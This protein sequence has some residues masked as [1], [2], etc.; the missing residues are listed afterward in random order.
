MG[1]KHLGEVGAFLLGVRYV[2][3]YTGY[4][5]LNNL[6]NAHLCKKLCTMKIHLDGSFLTH[7]QLSKVI[8]FD[9]IFSLFLAI[10]VE[11]YSISMCF[12]FY[13]Y[14]FIDSVLFFISLETNLHWSYRLLVGYLQCKVRLMID[15]IQNTSALHIERFRVYFMFRGYSGSFIFILIHLLSTKVESV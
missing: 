2:L 5:I 1:L 8:N 6:S 13:F 11:G 9:I 12:L 15:A 10:L 4:P 7:T 3:F 14:R